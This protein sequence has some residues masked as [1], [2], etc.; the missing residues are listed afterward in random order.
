MHLS[1]CELIITIIFDFVTKLIYF[2][3]MFTASPGKIALVVF[4]IFSIGISGLN[5]QTDKQFRKFI[6]ELDTAKSIKS[7]KGAE[8]NFTKLI[9]ENKRIEQS[10]YYGTL[11][12][13]FL[14][15]ECDIIEIEDYCRRADMYLKKLD[16]LSPDNSE[17]QVLFSMSAAAKIRVDPSGRN[18]KLGA[19][20]NK[21]A[22]RAIALNGNNPRAFLIKAKTVL[23]APPKL[24]GG[25]KFAIKF[26]E[27]AIEKY[28]SYK[29]LS[30]TEPDWGLD[31]AK[32]ELQE[33]KDITKGK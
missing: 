18:A 31:M 15:F 26:Y 10:L 27:K 33:C 5:A 4:A 6:N 23:N 24:G 16:S 13:L 3:Y 21:Y 25:P 2:R 28:K 9:A 19:V 7:L 12:N 1:T 11:A 32:K 14:A 20:A 29:P 22:E 30:N 8:A 17:I